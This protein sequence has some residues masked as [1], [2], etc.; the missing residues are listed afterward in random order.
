[1]SVGARHRCAGRGAA[2]EAHRMT[3]R[4]TA[5]LVAVALALLAAVLVDGRALIPVPPP[6]TPEGPPLLAVPLDA[7]ARIEWE[8]DGDRLTLLRTPAG[9]HDAAGHPWPRDVIDVALDALTSLHPRTV[10]PSSGLDLAEYG[11]APAAER[12]RV[13]DDTGHELLAMDIGNR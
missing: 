3:M 1:A 13:L 10:A 12:L 7:V 11:L 2:R 9:W 4:G 5:V 6:P 8:R